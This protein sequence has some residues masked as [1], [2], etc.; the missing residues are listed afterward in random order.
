MALSPAQEV[1]LA[2]THRSPVGSIYDEHNAATVFLGDRLTFLR[3]IPDGSAGLVVSSPPYNIGKRYEQ[4]ISLDSYIELQRETLVEATRVLAP[5]GSLCWQVGN[6]IATDKE[7]VPLDIILYP[8]CKALGL[9]LRNRII[10]H[11]DHGLHA[12]K[13][14]SGRYETIMWFT[15]SDDY[16]FHLDPVRVP[17]K[18]PGKRYF[19][20]PRM[21]ELSANPL[22]KNPSDLWE[23]PNV[24][25]NHPEKTEHPCQFP[26][27]LI[28]RLV[29]AL[30]NPGGLVVDPY[31]G[32]GS[33]AC[34]AVLHDRRAA[35][36]EIIER[37]VAIARLRI[38][39]A[40]EGRLPRR[41]MDRPIY[42]PDPRSKVA[43]I[44]DRGA[45]AARPKQLKLLND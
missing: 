33:A 3:S 35:G 39:A 42:Q 14:F 24:K 4:R 45:E 40:M 36:A 16:V 10:W 18:Y 11:F 15:K 13:R 31:L 2:V 25:H 30:T 22:G 12:S 29:L 19:K 37:Y 34:A 9:K 1:D 7:V 44:P 28:E 20:G 38:V 27:E 43:Q 17:Q 26:I 6:H 8:V 5:N 21:G 41:P 32:V 23:I